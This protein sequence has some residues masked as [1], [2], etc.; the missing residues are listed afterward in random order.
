MTTI[1][2]HYDVIEGKENTFVKAFLNTIN[3]M[4]SLP[5]HLET[6]MFEDVEKKGSYVILSQWQ[7]KDDFESFIHSDAFKQTVTWGKEN[8]LKGRPQHKVYLNQ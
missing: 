7:N 6:R 1:G 4:K 2:M 8:I 3:V 5:G